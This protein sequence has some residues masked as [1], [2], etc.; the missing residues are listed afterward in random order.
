MGGHAEHPTSI[1]TRIVAS[2]PIYTRIK[3]YIPLVKYLSLKRKPLRD[4]SIV[5]RFLFSLNM[6]DEIH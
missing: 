2:K 1:L 3:Y 5:K 4:S 6:I